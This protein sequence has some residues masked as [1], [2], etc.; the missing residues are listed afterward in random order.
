MRALVKATRGF[1]HAVFIDLEATQREADIIQIGAIKADLDK[2]GLISS[3]KEG[4][5]INIRP[6]HKVG[7]YVRNLTGITDEMLAKCGVPFAE[8]L[9]KLKS[10]IGGD[11]GKSVFIAFG[12]NDARILDQS[13]TFHPDADAH[14]VHLMKKNYLDF[15][16]FLGRYIHDERGNPYSLSNALKIFNVPFPGNAHD[17]LNDAKAL[18]A[19]YDA[20]SKNP[21]VLLTEYRKSISKSH[22]LPEAIR[23]LLSKLEENGSVDLDDYIEAL[24]ESLE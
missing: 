11:A 10:Y 14:Y 21:P 8:A 12:N 19:L 15:S 17:G 9:E 22:H 24:K 18:V 5:E 1:R 13:L 6:S 20:F 4:F 7:G 2:Q 23:R 16:A 3:I